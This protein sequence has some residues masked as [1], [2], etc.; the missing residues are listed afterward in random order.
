GV[1]SLFQ[2]NVQRQ[3]PVATIL[4][5]LIPLLG[6]INA[7]GHVHARTLYSAVNVI[8]RCPPG[9]ILATLANNPDFENVGEHYWKLS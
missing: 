1:D 2:S 7:Q 5:M 6:G 3:Q 8:R 9:P 4:R